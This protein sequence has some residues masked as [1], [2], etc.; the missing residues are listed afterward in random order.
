[1]TAPQHCK[2]RLS[3]PVLMH[4]LRTEEPE[5]AA[6]FPRLSN[7]VIDVK[8]SRWFSL[9]ITEVD[10]SWVFMKERKPSLIIATLEALAVLLSLK[11]F[12]GDQPPEGMN[13]RVQVVLGLTT[14]G[15]DRP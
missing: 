15:M 12:Y 2:R 6:G 13:T 8:S 5:L 4:R 7:G 14:A 1:M 3:H 10:F 9:E 11:V